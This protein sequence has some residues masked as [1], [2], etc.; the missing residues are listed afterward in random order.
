MKFNELLYDRKTKPKPAK[1]AGR[2]SVR[3]PESIENMWQKIER[4]AL[5]SIRHGNFDVRVNS[6]QQHFHLATARCEF[7]GV[8]NQVTYYLLQAIRVTGN[9]TRQRVEDAQ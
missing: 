9:R 4:N 6:F 3:L 8:A 7:D 2:R 5:P 1:L